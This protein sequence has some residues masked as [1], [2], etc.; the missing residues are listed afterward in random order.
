MWLLLTIYI[1]G[2]NV[3]PEKPILKMNF[4]FPRWDMFVPLRVVSTTWAGC[5]TFLNTKLIYPSFFQTSEIVQ[6]CSC[7]H[8]MKNKHVSRQVMFAVKFRNFQPN[9][10]CSC[11]RLK[12]NNQQVTIS[13]YHLKLTPKLLT[14]ALT[15][16]ALENPKALKP[17][18]LFE[19]PYV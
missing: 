6:Y 8:I 16:E 4:L 9:L 19:F 5:S 14:Q 17:E 2:T 7:K 15:N 1:L 10:C 13:I 18:V 12:W 11:N 3:S